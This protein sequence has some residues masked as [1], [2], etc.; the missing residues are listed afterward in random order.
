MFFYDP[1]GGKYIS[2]IWKPDIFE[3]RDFQVTSA[4]LTSAVKENRVKVKKETI[5]EDIRIILSGIC[6]SI[7]EL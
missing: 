4:N 6:S 2:V 5:L 1:C 3:V 7:E